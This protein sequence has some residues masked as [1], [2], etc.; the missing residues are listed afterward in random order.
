MAVT[1]PELV[2][3]LESVDDEIAAVEGELA[4][5][6]AELSGISKAIVKLQAERV[7]LRQIRLGRL[8]TES[9]GE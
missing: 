3:Q 6:Y 9:S 7:R 8:P 1:K 5:K 4:I 2:P